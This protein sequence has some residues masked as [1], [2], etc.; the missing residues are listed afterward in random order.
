VE[1]AL[2]ISLPIS[3]SITFN[4]CEKRKCG[5]K[6]AVGGKAEVSTDGDKEDEKTIHP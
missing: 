5:G 4:D 6:K 3:S 2:S 1:T